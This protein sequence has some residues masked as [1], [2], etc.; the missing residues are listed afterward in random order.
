MLPRGGT[1]TFT[2]PPAYSLSAASQRALHLQINARLFRRATGI[3]DSG[4]EELYA[5]ADTGR[6]GYLCWKGY[7]VTFFPPG[8][9]DGHT[10]CM[11]R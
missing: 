1:P 4:L 5:G 8:G 10:L 2:Q 3:V 11:V 6:D 9:G 7:V